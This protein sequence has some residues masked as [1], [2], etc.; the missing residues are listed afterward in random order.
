MKYHTKWTCTVG[1]VGPRISEVWK[2]KTK[3]AKDTKVHSVQWMGATQGAKAHRLSDRGSLG[4][5][6]L[7]RETHSRLSEL[8]QDPVDPVDPVA[9][10][11]GLDQTEEHL[12]WLVDAAASVELPEGWITFPDD[13]GRAVYYHERKLFITRKHPMLQRF[14]VYAEQ[15]Q[16]FYQTLSSKALNSTKIRAH[17]AVILNEVL[18]RCHR[19]LPPMTPV[20]SWA[21][22]SAFGHWHHIRVCF[23]NKGTFSSLSSCEF[24]SSCGTCGSQVSQVLWTWWVLQFFRRLWSHT[25]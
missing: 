8:L 16:K 20:L 3:E 11:L 5:S 18:N 10:E 4:N 14:K 13:D 21:N 2:P 23:V 17:L 24:A 7:S 25:G 9:A 1:P 22:C 6:R 19:E 12:L 15:L